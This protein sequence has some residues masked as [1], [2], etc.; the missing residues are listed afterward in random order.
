MSE[1]DPKAAGMDT[2][3][4]DR[5]RRPESP[6][7]RS[8]TLA[9]LALLAVLTPGAAIAQSAPSTIARSSRAVTI[10]Q[11]FAAHAAL[12]AVFARATA[13]GHGAVATARLLK[14]LGA[15]IDSQVALHG[16]VSLNLGM[17][18][19]AVDAVQRARWSSEDASRFV[20][21][22]QRHWSEDGAAKG[23]LEE[24]IAQVR[25]GLPIDEILESGETL[26]RTTAS[27]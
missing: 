26:E 10:S 14:P 24:M 17:L 16:S 20:V 2:V 27:R 21:A 19:D 9:L 15:F 7:P 4:K 3:R 11:P 6:E 22:L 13:R 18:V 5:P 8:G 12:Q 1:Q 25:Y 23:R